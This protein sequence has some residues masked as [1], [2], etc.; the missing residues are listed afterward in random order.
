MIY[1]I[2]GGRNIAVP[3]AEVFIPKTNHTQSRAVITMS[4]I[5]PSMFILKPSHIKLDPEF[6]RS[7]YLDS[8][9]LSSS[10]FSSHIASYAF[11]K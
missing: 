3:S 5:I 10:K 7:L 9:K 2:T 6:F 1:I 11:E 4:K 8:D